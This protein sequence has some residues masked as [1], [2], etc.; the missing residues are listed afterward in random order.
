MHFQNVLHLILGFTFGVWAFY[1]YFHKV[2]VIEYYFK[3]YINSRYLISGMMGAF[4][5]YAI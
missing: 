3:K 4:M 2:N 1:F 5:V